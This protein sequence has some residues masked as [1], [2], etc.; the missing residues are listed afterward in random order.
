MAAT[1]ELSETNLVG[2]VVTNGISTLN[3]GGNDRPN[4]D[5]LTA[6]DKI[7]PGNYS[8]VKYIRIH[9]VSQGSPAVNL[10]G[11]RF[12]KSSGTYKSGVGIGSN[13]NSSSIANWGAFG[14]KSYATPVSSQINISDGRNS[15]DPLAA[16]PAADPGGTNLAINANFA[17]SLTAAN[18]FS[19]YLLLQMYTATNTPTG[20]SSP[21]YTRQF[22]YSWVET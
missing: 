3:F 13:V 2:A 20:S 7:V 18:T 15:S 12:W 16:I 19:D 14:A 6:G 1:V 5:F 4:I 17:N 10:S 22:T 11:I 21:T 8:Y 9:L